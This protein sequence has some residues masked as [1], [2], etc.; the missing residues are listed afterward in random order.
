[1]RTTRKAL[2]MKMAQLAKRLDGQQSRIAE[3]EK[4][5]VQDHLTLKTLKAAAH[6]MGCRL[7]VLFYS[8]PKAP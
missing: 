7:L 6:A 5:E 1:V 3:I 4:T 8:I 2:G